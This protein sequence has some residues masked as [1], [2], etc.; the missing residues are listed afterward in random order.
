MYGSKQF[1]LTAHTADGKRSFLD[2]VYTP[3]SDERLFL[4]TG[5]SG[6]IRSE[7]IK[8]VA[9]IISKEGFP[10][11][12]IISCVDANKL[13]GVIF[14]EIGVYIF[15]AEE[16]EK[17]DFS[18]CDCTQ[19]IV[20]LGECCDRS[21]LYERREEIFTSHNDKNTHLQ[22]CRKFLSAASSMREDTQRIIGKSL[23]AEKLEKFVTRFV[24]KE[25]GAVAE[26]TGRLSVRFLDALTPDGIK[27][28]YETVKNI[29]ARIFV[30]DD[31]FFIASD[32]LIN[33]IKDAALM[34]GY[35]V[36]L[37]PDV[38]DPSKA[39]HVIIPQLSLCFFTNSQLCKWED[40]YTKKVNFTRFVDRETVKNH[41]NRV[42]FNN[43]AIE[44]LVGQACVNLELFKC[45][46]DRLD[47]I[48][49]QFCNKEKIDSYIERT[50]DEILCA[51]TNHS[52]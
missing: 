27:T 28:E 1:Y 36:I 14:E 39:R 8:N 3:F 33:Q 32:A 41:R 15:D 26:N 45:E 43:D 4:V 17:I 49:E 44:E 13:D 40:E 25:F 9:K 52:N 16:V 11:E 50:V 30:L 34:C 46:D 31:S 22:R 5:A 20:D 19:Y 24:K 7:F 12:K 42:K 21:A 37:C 47:D 29:C 6:I 23:N 35:D 51:I 38:L 48:Y 10:C 18:I 2:S